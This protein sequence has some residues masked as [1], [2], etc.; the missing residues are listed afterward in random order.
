MKTGKR[1]TM[2]MNM[3]KR[4]AVLLTVF[5][6]SFSLA[7]C[8]SG[9]EGSLKDNLIDG[10]DHF[11][12]SFS[13]HALTKDKNLQGERAPGP[14]EYTGSYTAHYEDFN[15]EEFLF[16]GTALERERGSNLKVSYTLEVTSGSAVLYWISSGEKH[17][18][19]NDGGED[20]YHLT[21]GSGDNYISLEGESFSGSLEMTVEDISVQEGGFGV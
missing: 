14:D 8:G 13:R 11:L 6:L 17:V 2:V 21:L 5:C 12:Q 1:R 20:V 18:I 19:A 3:A 10:F 4:A 16:G 15:G 7:G 9:Q